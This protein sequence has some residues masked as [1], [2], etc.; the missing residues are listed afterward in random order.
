MLDSCPFSFLLS[1]FFGRIPALAFIM[2][3]VVLSGTGA[4]DRLGTEEVNR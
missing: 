1:T 3:C 2:D 4:N